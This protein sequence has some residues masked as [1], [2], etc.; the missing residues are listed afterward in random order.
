M[1]VLSRKVGQELVIGDDIRIVV[2]R[3][4][5]GRVTLAVEA[6]PETL[7]LRGELEPRARGF[8]PAAEDD[9]AAPPLAGRG[10]SPRRAV[11]Q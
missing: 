1:L 11:T 2:N 9:G 5:G 10:R 3:V 6:P 8:G 7:I 4:A